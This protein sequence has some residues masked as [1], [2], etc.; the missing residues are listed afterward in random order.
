MSIIVPIIVIIIIALQI[1]FFAKNVKRMIE[2]K[3]I[4]KDEDTWFIAKNAETGFVS[5]ID[6]SGNEVFYSIR[7]SINKYLSNSAGSVIDYSLLKDA[8]DRHCDSVENDINTLTP[9]PL[10]LGLA[11]T[12][13]G[14]IVGLG[15]L[16]L[17]GSIAEL[18]SS[19][20]GSFGTAA[21]GVNDLLNGVAW[22]MIASI[23]GIIFTTTGSLLFK[24]Y[25]LEGESG[26]NTF[27]AWL[28]GKLLP[29]L[30]SDT[31]DALNKLVKNLNKFNN[32]FATNTTSLRSALKEV[33][34]SY[35]IQGDIIQ[36]VHDM[37]VMKMARA[38]V[39]VLQ[40]LKECT[41]KL[42]LFNEYLDDIHGYTDAIHTFTSQFES[43]A[44][45]LHIL[46]EISEFFKRHKA[47]IAKESADVDKALRDSLYAIKETAGTNAQEL[48]YA[49]VTQAEEFKRIILEEKESF[50]QISKE[51]KSQFDAQLGHIPMLERRLYEIS[52]IPSKLDKLI[53]RIDRSNKDLASYINETLK[54]ITKGQKKTTSTTG[55]PIPFRIDT[56]VPKW[57]K[58]T[59]IISIITIAVSC[60]YNM[61][62]DI[63][64]SSSKSSTTDTKETI[65]D[66]PVSVSEDST[67]TKKDST[68]TKMDSI[69][70]KVGPIGIYPSPFKG[71]KNIPKNT[72]NHTVNNSNPVVNNPNSPTNKT[73][74]I[75]TSSKPF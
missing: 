47:E 64:F 54:Q 34:E 75:P 43:E 60:F 59:I 62:N 30:P 49:L 38:N 51:I 69:T 17:T 28:Q 68:T 12:M 56:S 11:G 63:F 73:N 35:R 5:G 25:K 22:A 9:V 32:T 42:E 57:M 16:Y 29:E 36:A 18:L 52:D 27:L 10:Y 3:E 66:E 58:W 33:N 13:A 23:F 6:G 44:N 24:R 20:T 4:F 8:V 65:V 67:T 70:K 45:R 37:D 53:E 46:E 72:A 21:N 61:A 71:E 41:D 48:H 55:S 19:G 1:R 40:E 14:V 7:D 26:K 50:E 39:R 31:S 2:Y 15:S 74:N